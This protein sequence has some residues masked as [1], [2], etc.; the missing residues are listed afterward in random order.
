MRCRR[1]A[2][3]T[4]RC[5]SA[6]TRADARGADAARCR[7]HASRQDRL[8][9]LHLG[10]HRRAQGRDALR[11]HPAGQRPGDGRGL[12]PRRDDSAATPQPAAATTSAP[13]RSNRRWWRAASSSCNDPPA[14]M[15][16]LDWI[17][18]T[19]ATY[20]MGVPT[21]AM[22]MLAELRQRGADAARRASRSST[23]RAHRSPPKPRAGF[24][25]AGHQAAERLRHDRERL[26][27]VHHADRSSD[28]SPHLRQGVHRL[29]SPAVATRTIPDLEALP[30][31]V[32]EIGGRGGLLMLGY[33][34]NQTA[35]E[36]SFNA[37][38]GS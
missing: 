13:S 2:R 22:D 8:S 9:R 30:G 38:A 14:G 27:P 37:A 1:C 7:Q 20:V 5:P 16:P 10:H 19:G 24:A 26:A 23:W 32:G 12:A 25:G 28:G 6:R 34:D 21:H 18:E 4:R 31:E 36:T 11:Q 3:P 35:T 15:T 33:F 29:R 17:I